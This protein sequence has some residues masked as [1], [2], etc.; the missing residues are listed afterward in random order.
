MLQIEVVEHLTKKSAGAYVCPPH[1]SLRV[2][3]GA[4]KIDM[5]EII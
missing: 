3:L 5:L 2:E 4:P 1:P